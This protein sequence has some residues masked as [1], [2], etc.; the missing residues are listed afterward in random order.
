MKDSESRDE[1]GT[2]H[3]VYISPHATKFSRRQRLRSVG[4]G[5]PE[6]PSEK[7]ALFPASARDVGTG[8]SLSLGFDDLFGT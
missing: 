5:I 4:Q 6:E 7:A 2:L 1:G 8:V 3:R